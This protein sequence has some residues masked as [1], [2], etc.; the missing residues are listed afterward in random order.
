MASRWLQQLMATVGECWEWQAPARQIC[1]RS[2]KPEDKG[3]CWE[4][5]VYPALQEILGGK[6]D[7][8]TGWGGFHFDISRLLE[9]FHA[10]HI[11]LSTATKQDPPKL[12]FEGKFH[13]RA[14]LLHVCLEPPEKELIYPGL[15][16]V[17][18]G[19]RWD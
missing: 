17:E 10:E 9:E 4:V 1:F 5:C 15:A 14:V 3:A 18:P 13:G 8:E 6:H 11:S 12:T 7:G 16:L 19:I 2:R